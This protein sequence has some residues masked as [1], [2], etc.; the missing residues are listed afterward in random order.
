ME[1]LR[2]LNELALRRP[3]ATVVAVGTFDGVHLGHSAVLT[4]VTRWAE[5][6]GALPAV[7]AFTRPPRSI[8]GKAERSDLIT[9]PAHRASLIERLGIRLLKNFAGM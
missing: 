2:T 3:A 6:L 1:T 7:L 4:E 9:S 5:D 8:L